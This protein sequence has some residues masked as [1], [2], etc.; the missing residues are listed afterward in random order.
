MM[1]WTHCINFP[2]SLVSGL[3]NSS[4]WNKYKQ[5]PKQGII[6]HKHISPFITP[7]NP[8]FDSKEKFSSFTWKIADASCSFINSSHCESNLHRE[9][10]SYY[11]YWGNGVILQKTTEPLL[12][13]LRYIFTGSPEF[14]SLLF[15][16]DVQQ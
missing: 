2:F 12:L 6:L 14:A 11:G 13:S 9:G 1:K 16:L 10:E 5:H 4:I 8:T 7:R 15:T 3:H